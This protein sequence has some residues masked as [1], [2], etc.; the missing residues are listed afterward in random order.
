MVLSALWTGVFERP[1]FRENTGDVRIFRATDADWFWSNVEF[2]ALASVVFC[3]IAVAII[4]PLA[5]YLKRSLARFRA[6]QASAKN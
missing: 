6:N 1:D 4:L 5:I 2:Y 3:L